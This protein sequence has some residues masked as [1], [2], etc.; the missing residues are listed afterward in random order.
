MASERDGIP[1]NGRY[2]TVSSLFSIVGGLRIHTGHGCE[3]EQGPGTA[4]WW[5]TNISGTLNLELQ[6]SVCT[7]IRNKGALG[8]LKGSS[9][10]K[11]L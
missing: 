5:H 3:G 9:R 4:P 7:A 2:A 8:S 10:V 6:G 1:R 11:P